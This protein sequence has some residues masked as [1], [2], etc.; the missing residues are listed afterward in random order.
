MKKL[1]LKL[2]TLALTLILNI[3]ITQN[4]YCMRTKGSEGSRLRNFNGATKMRSQEEIKEQEKKQKK[5][6]L[7]IKRKVGR[8]FYTTN[9]LKTLKEETKKDLANLRRGAITSTTRKVKRIYTPEYMKSLETGTLNKPAP[10]SVKKAL[11][12]IPK[13]LA[14]KKISL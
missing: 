14:L 5:I 4:T 3:T 12:L 11:K 8:K 6:E 7:R 10:Q 9:S 1:I 2:S 13:I